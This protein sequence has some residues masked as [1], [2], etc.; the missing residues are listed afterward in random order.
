MRWYR[1]LIQE[2]KPRNFE[3]VIENDKLV[4]R[5]PEKPDEKTKNKV[6]TIIPDGVPVEYKIEAKT[7]TLALLQSALMRYG[8]T[9]RFNSKNRIFKIEVSGINKDHAVWNFINTALEDDGFYKKWIVTI[10]GQEA[11]TYDVEK[12]KEMKKVA[13]EVKNNKRDKVISDDD[14]TNLKISLGKTETVD[15]FLKSLE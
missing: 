15:D 10:D 9:G 7:S 8:V 11:Y 1:D 13:D 6:S 5:G 12:I 2:L 14:V 4:I 3:G